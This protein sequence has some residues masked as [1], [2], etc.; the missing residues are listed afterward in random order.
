MEGYCP[1]SLCTLITEPRI[2]TSEEVIIRDSPVLP[3]T[4][5]CNLTSS[6]HTLTYS[7]WTKNGVEL[8]ATRKNA[9]NMEYRINKPRAEDSGEYHCVYHFVSAP[10]AN[11]TIEVKDRGTVAWEQSQDDHVF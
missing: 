1:L 9:S 8:S 2:V 5:Q 3:V 6:S 4:L 7:Y 10:K 11:A